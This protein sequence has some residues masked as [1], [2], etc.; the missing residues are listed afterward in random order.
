[1]LLQ[2]RLGSCSDGSMQVDQKQSAF[3]EIPSIIPV[4]VAGNAAAKFH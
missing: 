3:F 1:M 2:K 4:Q